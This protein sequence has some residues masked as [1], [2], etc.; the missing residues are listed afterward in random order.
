MAKDLQWMEDSNRSANRSIH[1]ISNPARRV[2][3]LGG[4]GVLTVGA[5][6]PWLEGRAAGR[7]GS[8]THGLLEIDP[9]DPASVPV[10]RTALGHRGGSKGRA[11]REAKL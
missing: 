5:L 9:Y 7:D 11:E 1:D 8:S 6:A 10:K 3:L 2:L 4:I